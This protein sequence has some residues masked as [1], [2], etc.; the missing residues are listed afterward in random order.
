MPSKNRNKKKKNQQNQQI[1]DNYIDSNISVFIK[2]DVEK[3]EKT[4]K[5]DTVT[6]DTGKSDTVKPDIIIKIEDNQNKQVE[7]N[8]EIEENKQ[9][10]LNKGEKIEKIENIK[11]VDKNKQNQTEEQKN[12]M[13]NK[14]NRNINELWK[15]LDRNITEKLIDTEVYDVI[16]RNYRNVNLISEILKI[17]IVENNFSDLSMEFITLAN[18]FFSH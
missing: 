15:Y 10:I 4:A 7:L 12:Y 5:P 2:N 11:I 18:S 9:N 1:Q 14:I 3:I 13:K 8:Q 16:P 17:K 6:H